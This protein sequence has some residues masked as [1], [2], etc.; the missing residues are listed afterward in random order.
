M[1]RIRIAT[2]KSA[3][4]PS[5]VLIPF[6]EKSFRMTTNADPA[7]DLRG[8]TERL[9]RLERQNERLRAQDRRVK[10]LFAT[11]LLLG[12]AG[13]LGGS[14]ATNRAGAAAPAAPRVMR[15]NAFIIVDRNGAERGE[16]G[17]NDADQ[18]AFLNLE[19]D[20]SGRIEFAIGRDGGGLRMTRGKND[21]SIGCTAKGG[22]YLEMYDKDGKAMF[23]QRKP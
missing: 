21:V 15:A 1:C 17:Y 7:C 16:F 11:L 2:S 10:A 18:F 3:L 14:I 13:W 20:K 12:A 22:T 6:L 4:A 23:E 8:L 19:P 5:L 9:E